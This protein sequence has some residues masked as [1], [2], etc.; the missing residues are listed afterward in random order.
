MSDPHLAN[1]TLPGML[2]VVAVALALAHGMDRVAAA[3]CVRYTATP[4]TL[5][6][7]GSVSA[8]AISPQGDV[9]GHLAC[10][11]GEDRAFVWWGSDPLAVLNLPNQFWSRAHDINSSGRIV[12]VAELTGTGIR[13]I[14]YMSGHMTDLG[15]LGQNG[16]SISEALAINEHDQ[17]VGYG[18]TP[19]GSANHAYLWHDG[20]ISDLN[21]SIGPNNQAND[22]N[23][24]SQIVGWMGTATGLYFYA[25]AFL[26][27]NGV[28]TPLG[29]P[30][31]ATNSNAN[32]ISNTG[33]ICGHY[34]IADPQ[35]AGGYKPRALAWINGQMV[36]LG[37]LPG[38]LNSRALDVNDSG[39]IVGNCNNPP[40][41]GNGVNAFLWRDGQMFALSDL[42]APEFAQYQVWYARN[43]N[44]SGQIA[45]TLKPPLVHDVGARLD[46]IPPRSG[47]T[48]CDWL[49]NVNDLL[50]IINAWGPAAAKTPFQGSPD[51]N[52]DGTVN[53]NDLL[54]VINDWG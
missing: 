2:A 17:V 48:N 39:T 24:R 7:N 16:T 50:N 5:G 35:G 1:T 20:V 41:L 45:A 53:V 32:A 51:L 10:I 22:I 19:S 49:V 8:Q 34:T 43:I 3:Q 12:G 13:P 27:H 38:Y 42:L 18:S 28:T 46:P 54:A 14:A 47:D 15:S 25:E 4:I 30:R 9:V 29:K 36:D 11:G 44:N 23:D 37:V 40:L 33:I 31:G 52:D 6:C 21:L 26:W